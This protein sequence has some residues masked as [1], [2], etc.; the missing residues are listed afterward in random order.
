MQNF[1]KNYFAVA[2]STCNESMV[3]SVCKWYSVPFYQ[4][5]IIK[6]K[7]NNCIPVL[8]TNTQTS[9]LIQQQRYHKAVTVALLVSL[10]LNLT[11]PG[12]SLLNINRYLTT[13]E[14]KILLYF[15]MHQNGNFVLK[16][17][18]VNVNKSTGKCLFFLV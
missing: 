14:L 16:I 17:S 7:N 10:V 8:N 13:T 18:L 2:V 15:R 6:K 4:C 11:Y 5:K 3:I 12:F 9:V 1:R